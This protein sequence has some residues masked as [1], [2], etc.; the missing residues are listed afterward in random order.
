MAWSPQ[1]IDLT[2]P[3]TQDTIIELAGKLGLDL[4]ETLLQTAQSR[5]KLI[6]FGGVG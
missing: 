6:R 2:R 4:A 1:L 3:M 5:G